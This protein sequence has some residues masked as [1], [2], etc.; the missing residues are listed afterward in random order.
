MSAALLDH[1]TEL[2]NQDL[3]LEA[4]IAVL[5]QCERIADTLCDPE[6]SHA[7]STASLT[8]LTLHLRVGMALLDLRRAPV[9][10]LPRPR[11]V[12]PG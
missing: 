3:K 7:L 11:V 2:R 10:K 4:L 9:R 6:L 8:A 1:G 12:V 5:R